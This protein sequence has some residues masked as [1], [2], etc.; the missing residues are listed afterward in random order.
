MAE[1]AHHREAARQGRLGA[2][3]LIDLVRVGV[4]RVRARVR[5]RVRVRVRARARVRVALVDRGGGGGGAE[6]GL[7]ERYSQV[8]PQRAW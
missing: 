1:E 7:G 4:V 3:T 5:A 6:G 2:L 8:Q